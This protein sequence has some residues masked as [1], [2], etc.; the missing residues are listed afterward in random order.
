MDQLDR[1]KFMARTGV[2]A[3][4]TGGLWLAPQILSPSTAFA[5]SSCDLRGRTGAVGN[6]YYTN[7]TWATQS[8]PASGTYPAL[9]LPTPTATV[10]GSATASSSGGANGTITTT[11]SPLTGVGLPTW[12]VYL[13]NMTSAANG[14]GFDAVFRFMEPAPST[15][16]VPVWDVRFRI[17]DIDLNTSGGQNYVDEVW[18]ES[19]DGVTVSATKGGTT[20]P[21][22]S[23][24]SA[25]PLRGSGNNAVTTGAYADFLLTG[26]PITTFT[27]RYRNDQAS[28]AGTQMALGVGGVSFCR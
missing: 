14:A 15:T 13:F 11:S 17:W 28:G 21:T 20:Q 24:T 9:R 8:W 26:G 6:D 7:M 18:V 12:A 23:G 27:V 19:N 25:S 2:G 10:V 1:R 5:G 22:G 4:A 16:P 3:A